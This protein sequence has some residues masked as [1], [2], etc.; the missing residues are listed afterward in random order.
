MRHD[1]IAYVYK[2][3]LFYYFNAPCQY[4]QLINLHLLIFKLTPFL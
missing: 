2:F 3:H 4:T 1:I